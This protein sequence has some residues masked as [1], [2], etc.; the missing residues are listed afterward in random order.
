MK[1]KL[2]YTSLL[3]FVTTFMVLPVQANHKDKQVTH[4][5]Q[6]ASMLQRLEVIKQMDVQSMSAEQKTGL[7]E[8]VQTIHKNLKTLDGGI[9]LS[10]GAIIIILLIILIIL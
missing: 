9:Y 6:A 5:Q 4:A 2:C 7:K 8:E 10:V 3:L 1:T